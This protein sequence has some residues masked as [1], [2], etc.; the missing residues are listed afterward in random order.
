MILIS[1]IKV[2]K[3][4]DIHSIYNKNKA[5]STADAPSSVVVMTFPSIVSH[6][7]ISCDSLVIAVVTVD[8]KISLIDVR[9]LDNIPAVFAQV[10][11]QATCKYQLQKCNCNPLMGFNGYGTP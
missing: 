1:D 11:L 9:S 7:L 4:S 5:S 8:K 3:K 10:S 6:L 2:Y